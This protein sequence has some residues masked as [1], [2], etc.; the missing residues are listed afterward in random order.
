MMLGNSKGANSA[1]VFVT[2]N[3]STTPLDA[4][5]TY[6]GS[7]VEC[8]D[9]PSVAVACLA[10]QNGTVS[11]EF[12]NDASTVQSSL[13]TTV[14]ASTNEVHRYTVT[15]RYVRVKLT[16]T[17]ASNQT[18]LDLSLILGYQD[19]LTSSINSIMQSDAD[20][21]VTRPLDFNLMVAEGLYQNRVNT[22]KDGFNNTVTSA[23]VPQD[24]WTN[25]GVYTGFPTGAVEN[26]EIVVAGADTGTVYYS[27]L[28][29]ETS[30]DYVIASKAV[31]GAGTYA[32]GH[33]VWRCNFMYYVR[34][35]KTLF[36][37]SLIT[38][39]NT[40]TTANVFCQIPVGYSQSYNC[41][42]T[43]PYGSAIYL[44]RVTGS[45]RGGTSASMDG[46][47]WYRAYGD[48]PRLR[49][50]FNLQFGTLYFDDIDYLIRIPELTDIMPRIVYST[51]ANSAE[52]EVSYRFVK[53]KTI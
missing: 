49:F 47:F 43:V 31:T 39:R 33:T 12:S 48:S 32:L 16:N 36:N 30:T 28:A 18:S 8:I 44:D 22:I 2:S 17:S 53:V 51:Q 23:N 20:G 15:R 21:I 1:G 45:V 7:W 14:T 6:T 4:G 27:Y 52:A 19:T 10:D 5:Q 34:T 38:L 13:S 46:H 35:D 9:F 3:R 26:G 41:A 40:V 42:Y 11:V 37:V 24:L 29:T 25:G 50:P